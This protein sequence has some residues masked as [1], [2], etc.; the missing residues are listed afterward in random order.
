GAGGDV[1]GAGFGV[2][3]DGFERDAAA[4]FDL[5][6][7]SDFG[8]PVSGFGGGE[9]IEEE[10]RGAGIEGFAELFAGAHFDFGGGAAGGAGSLD[11]GA[12]SAGGGDV[13][14][15][16]QDRVVEA[17]AVIV[18]AAGLRGGFFERAESGSGF[19]GIEDFALGATDGIGELAGEGGD[20]AQALE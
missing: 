18:G 14:V 6:A 4:Q 17:H 2:G 12:H 11:G 20:A 16:D 8:D 3:A 19:A 9:V 10:G 1:V 5:S 7:A 15:L 13:I